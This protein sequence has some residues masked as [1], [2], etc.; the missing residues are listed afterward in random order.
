MK[1]IYMLLCTFFFSLCAHAG[2]SLQ[3]GSFYDFMKGDQSTYLKRIHNGGTSTAFV[4]IEIKEIFYQ[5]NGNSREEPLKSVDGSTRDGLVASPARLIVPAK[6][7]QGTR[8]LYTGD[9]SKE[10]Y[11][12][13]R[14]L[15]VVPEKEDKFAVSDT[16]RET[17]EKEMS[18]GFNVMAGYGMVFFVRP[19][20]I[21]FDTKIDNTANAYQ[22]K[23][24]GNSV[25][26]IDSF[27][28][29]S[30][31]NEDDCQPTRKVHLIPG[32][33]FAFDK[34]AGR[35]YRYNLIEDEKKTPVQVKG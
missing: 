22:V 31:K 2:P 15:P 32:H 18:A 34:Q 1:S 9:R 6:G 3:I 20:V 12:R 26:V 16:E 10:R 21:R 30:A 24:N 13:V 28:D 25:V 23:N 4:K 19:S 27:K 29:C 8:L 33:D 35:V 7:T 11:F 14:F 5:Q 17:Y